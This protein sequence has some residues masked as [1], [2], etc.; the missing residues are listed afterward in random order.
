[1]TLSPL[2]LLLLLLAPAASQPTCSC[3]LQP[4]DPE[5]LCVFPTSEGFCGA[6]P[7]AARYQ[8]SDG[9]EFLCSTFESAGTYFE[10]S[11]V[12]EPAGEFAC[13]PVTEQLA[14]VELLPGAF[15]RQ[16]CFGNFQ[17]YQFTCNL[18]PITPFAVLFYS[19][20]VDGAGT[21]TFREPEPSEVSITMTIS[22]LDQ[23]SVGTPFMTPEVGSTSLSL[24]VPPLEQPI[25]TSYAQSVGPLIA[26]DARFD[27]LRSASSFRIFLLAEFRES[28]GNPDHFNSIEGCM[29]FIFSN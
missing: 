7:C 14:R 26:G 10:A 25:T 6:A 13:A 12:V 2:L 15:T 19:Y 22:A 16:C 21:F 24:S 23:S 1:M 18:A 3:A 9:G 29:N 5:N 11:G 20:N 17:N 28:S 27:Y 8:C 4:A